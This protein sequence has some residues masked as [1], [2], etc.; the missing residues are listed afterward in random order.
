MIT[1]YPTRANKRKWNN[2]F[3]KLSAPII[4]VYTLTQDTT[5]API[6]PFCKKKKKKKTRDIM[7]VNSRS[8]RA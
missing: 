7:P 8:R 6:S 5:R 4:I 1:S 2:C 3:S